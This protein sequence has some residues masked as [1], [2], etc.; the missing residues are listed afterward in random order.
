[1][2]PGIRDRRSNHHLAFLLPS[3]HRNSSFYISLLD[4][5]FCITFQPNCITMSSNYSANFFANLQELPA[6]ERARLFAQL[7]AEA[8]AEAAAEPLPLAG[9][10]TEESAEDDDI[11]VLPMARRFTLE[12]RRQFAHSRL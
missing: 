1:M 7:A 11:V 5:E 10:L 4:T 8:A 9:P 3:P 6:H 12:Q 2:A